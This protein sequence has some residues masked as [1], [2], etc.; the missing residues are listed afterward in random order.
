M[1]SEGSYNDYIDC[2]CVR[3]VPVNEWNMYEAD[4]IGTQVRLFFARILKYITP[5]LSAFGLF[6]KW[7]G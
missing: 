3:Y 5:L 2:A 1:I 7:F 4:E 6:Y